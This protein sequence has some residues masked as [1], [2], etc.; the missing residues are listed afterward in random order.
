M[1]G[2]FGGRTS[3][4]SCCVR[5]SRRRRWALLAGVLPAVPSGA[6]LGFALFGVAPYDP[7]VVGSVLG[8][9]IT[10]AWLGCWMPARR[11]T[12][13]DPLRALAAE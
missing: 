13:L 10:A 6:L 5:G 3:F 7:I 9:M 11:A 1:G 8:V 4:G 12:R 2:R